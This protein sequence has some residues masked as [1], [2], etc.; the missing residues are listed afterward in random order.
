MAGT[1]YDTKTTKQEISCFFDMDC[2]GYFL[3]S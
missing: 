2:V 1:D 3:Y